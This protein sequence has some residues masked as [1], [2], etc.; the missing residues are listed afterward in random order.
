MVGTFASSEQAGWLALALA[1]KAFRAKF[2]NQMNLT[3][4]NASILIVGVE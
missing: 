3:V 4:L 1:V 2:L